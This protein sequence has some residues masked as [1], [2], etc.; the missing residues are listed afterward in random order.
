MSNEISLPQAYISQETHAGEIAITGSRI[1]NEVIERAI[2]R[3]VAYADIFDYPL[4]VP[5]ITRY[6]IGVS[7]SVQR[8]HAILRNGAT[9]RRYL[10]VHGNFVSF[11][12]RDEIIQT[13]QRRARLAANLWPKASH[14]GHLIAN[15]PF[16]RMVAVTGA[17]AMDNVA[18]NADLDYLVVTRPGRLWSCRALIIA[19]VRWAARRGDIICPNYFLSERALI[20]AEH[21]LYTAHELVQ[22]VPTAG[23]GTYREMRWLNGW[24]KDY[25]PNATRLSLRA[26]NL[27]DGDSHLAQRKNRLRSVAET[28]LRSPLAGWFERWEMNRKIDRFSF[29]QGD[30]PE[31][32]FCADWCKG[33]FDGH[34]RQTLSAYAQRLE[35]LGL[36]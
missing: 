6:L 15:L 20:F 7:A 9:V 2:I 8:V 25:L 11:A 34:G 19:L 5:E 33:H 27:L 35:D 28:A 3:T 24:T 23:W 17:L 26:V 29:N 21:N 31:A 13:R 10:R 36:A 30:W 16:V 22:M 1:S 14:Y 18:E 32:A 12:W 4:T